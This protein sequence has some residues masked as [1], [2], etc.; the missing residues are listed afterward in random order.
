MLDRLPPDTWTLVHGQCLG[1]GVGGF[2]L[3]GGVN[4][5]GSTARYGAAMEQVL[6]YTLVTAEGELVTVTE[7][8]VVGLEEG[9]PRAGAD[10][11]MGLRGA[12]GSYGVVTQFLVR[13]YPAPETLASVIPVWVSSA[14]DLANVQR[15]AESAKGRGFQFGLYSLYYHK[16]MREPWR[17]PLLWTSQ[18]ALRLQ[19]WAAGEPGTPMVISAA[20]I[21]S[22]G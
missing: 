2:T 17:H 5:V 6:E 15:A 20:D 13:V 7:G 21:R 9:D 3:G 18:L 8:G 11:L 10:I 19:A 16:A 1:V 22:P 12:G 14:S 4:M